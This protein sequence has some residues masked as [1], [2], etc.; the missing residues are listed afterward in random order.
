MRALTVDEVIARALER[1][2]RYTPKPKQAN[3]QVAIPDAPERV[4]YDGFRVPSRTY[5]IR[6]EGFVKIGIASDVERRFRD[7]QSANPH[8]LECLAVLPGGRDV[9][10]RLHA[11]FAA[12]RTHDEWFRIEGDLAAWIDGGF[13]DG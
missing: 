8:R 2:E 4:R 1:A 3:I 11:R 5:V 7:L 9:E 12:Q 6:C 13:P 10:R